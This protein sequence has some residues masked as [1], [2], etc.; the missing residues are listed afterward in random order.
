VTCISFEDALKQ[1]ESSHNRPTLL[2]GNGFGIAYDA[3]IFSYKALFRSVDWSKAERVQRVFES[4]KTWDFELAIRNIEIAAT[5]ADIYQWGYEA[6]STLR[7]DADFLKDALLRAI[8]ETHPA[9]I[10]EVDSGRMKTT[11]GF[12]RNF[13]RIFSLNYD[14]LLYWTLVQSGTGLSDLFKDG[15]RYSENVL[16]WTDFPNQRVLYLHGALHLFQ[17]NGRLEKI[18]YQSIAGGRLI[19]QIAERVSNGHAPLFVCEG[20]NQQKLVHIQSSKYLR[21]CF[22]ALQSAT[23]VLFIY[24]HSLG[25]P[26]QHILDAISG[27]QIK[28]VFISL[29]GDPGSYHNQMIQSKARGIQLARSYGGPVV[30][31]YQAESAEIW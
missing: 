17:E 26:D 28:E 11:A 13:G 24:G 27:S 12:L 18:K 30:H 14:L 2:L 4:L 23:G 7:D 21:Y 31:F 22:R 3:N 6:S 29:Y 9:H 15:F 16:E 20:T 10:F 5:I 8:Q 25:D 19:Q 1:A